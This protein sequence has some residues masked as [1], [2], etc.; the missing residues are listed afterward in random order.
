M[1]NIRRIQPIICCGGQGS[2]LYPLSTGEIPKQ[3]ISLGDRGTLLEETLRRVDIVMKKCAAMNYIVHEP[4][5]IMNCHH[6]LPIELS[7]Y[8]DNVLYEEFAND[9]AVAIARAC[10]EIKKKFQDES[11]IMLVLPA[12]HYIYNDGAFIQDITSGITHV[13]DNNIVLYGIVPTAPETKYGYI[14]PQSC[15]YDKVT[16]REKPNMTTALELIDQHALWNSGIFSANTDSILNY[17]QS[18]P[19]DIMDYIINPRDGK[20]PSF[21]IAVLQEHNN[22]YTQHCHGWKWSDIGTWD[23]FMDVPEIK[24]EMRHSNNITKVRCDNV[25][26]LKRS[27]GNIVI[28]GCHNLLVVSNGPDILI[29]SNNGDYNNDLKEVATRINTK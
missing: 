14:I 26:V 28:I 29:M 19:Y 3:F 21:D 13:N 18:S 12:D 4:L 25:N 6:K 17:L 7:K 8:Q 22:I 20:A 10:L 16:F 1:S 2:R 24:E 15:T 5:L 9:T 27:D 11:V 23:A